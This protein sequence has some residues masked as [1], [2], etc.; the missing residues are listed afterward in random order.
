ML[1]KSAHNIIRGAADVS[2]NHAATQK[3]LDWLGKG[4]DRNQS[5]FSNKK[6]KVLLMGSCLSHSADLGLTGTC[7]P[8]RG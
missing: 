1:S 6:C 8:G 2:G 7:H 3:N 5:K 4:S